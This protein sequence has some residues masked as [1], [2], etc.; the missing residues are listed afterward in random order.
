MAIARAT[1]DFFESQERARR[2]TFILSLSFVLALALIVALVYLVINAVGWIWDEYHVGLWHPDLLFKVAFCVIVVVSIGCL[3][4]ILDLRRGGEAV[5]RILGATRVE[6]NTTDVD[7]RRLLNVVEEISIA[8]GIPV[9]QVFILQNESSINAFAAGFN[10]SNAIVA[11]TRGCILELTRDELQ[12]VVAH[13]FSHILNGDMSLNVRLMGI[14]SGILVL[15]MI[16]KGIL[17]GKGSVLHSERNKMPVF[18]LNPLMM[19]LGTGLL[20]IGYIGA[21][22]STLIKCAVSRQREFLADA[23]AV[24]FTRNPSGIAG[25]LKKMAGLDMGSRITNPHAEEASHFFFGNGLSESII[26]ALATHPPIHERIRRI[27]PFAKELPET[28]ALPEMREEDE[29][30]ISFMTAQPETASGTEGKIHVP[31]DELLSTV[32]VSQSR[33]IDYAAALLAQIPKGIVEATRDPFGATAVIYCLL[34]NKDEEPRRIQLDRLEHHADPAVLRQ[35]RDLIPSTYKIHDASRMALVDLCI[36]SLR[37]LSADQ[38][39][40]LVENVG[41]VVEADRKINL[42][43]YTLQKMIFHHLDPIFRHKKRAEARYHVID[44]VIIECTELLSTLAWQGGR[45]AAEAEKA[46]KK[47]MEQLDIEILPPLVPMEKCTL[48]ALDR[49]LD[50]LALA[51]FRIKKR[52]IKGCAVCLSADDWITTKEAEL[53]RAIACSLDCPIPPFVPGEIR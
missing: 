10:P 12:G 32:G 21:L 42:F 26:D 30:A 38:Y 34:F 9:P 29:G 35:S 19:I 45:G 24:R 51:S 13:E 41:H 5:A 20:V 52:L 23:S 47:G 16:G 28:P 40:N 25:A 46:Y 44:Q 18:I 1:M 7:E 4:K 33:H 8:S 49:A 50:R 3:D 48:R 36:P 31:A 14:V 2:K 43:E 15:S 53:I 27:D 6:P 37:L 39:R 11:V 17:G 22:F